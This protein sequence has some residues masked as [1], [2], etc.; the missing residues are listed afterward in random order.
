MAQIAEGDSG[1]R[2]I[3]SLNALISNWPPSSDISDLIVA[4]LSNLGPS[5]LGAV[6]SSGMESPKLN[7]HHLKCNIG[8]ETERHQQQ[9]SLPQLRVGVSGNSSP[10]FC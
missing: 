2:L 8:S 1:H 5:A 3:L 7:L 4:L 6:G 10:S 9:S